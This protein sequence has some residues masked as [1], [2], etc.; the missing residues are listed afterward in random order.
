MPY[1][2][3]LLIVDFFFSAKLLFF[4]AVF[5]PAASLVKEKCAE[6]LLLPSFILTCRCQGAHHI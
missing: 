3:F 2:N 5:F 6:S 1:L 4:S